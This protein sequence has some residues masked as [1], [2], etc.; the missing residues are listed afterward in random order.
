MRRCISVLFPVLLTLCSHAQKTPF[1]L[2][3][4]K[5]PAGFHV[6][7][8]AQVDGPRM[9]TFTPGGVLLV[10]ETGEGKVETRKQL[11]ALLWWSLM[12]NSSATWS[13]S[14][15]ENTAGSKS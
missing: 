7:V 1:D 10:S 3:Q 11:P 5:L 4:L 12:I 13:V 14:K 6:A 2:K 8:F 9:L 15:R